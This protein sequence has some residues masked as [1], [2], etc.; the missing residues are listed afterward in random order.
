[1]ADLRMLANESEVR[2]VITFGTKKKKYH[3]ASLKPEDFADKPEIRNKYFWNKIRSLDRFH[4]PELSKSEYEAIAKDFRRT[5]KFDERCLK[6]ETASSYY[7]RKARVEA[8][9]KD[10]GCKASDIDLTDYIWDERYYVRYSFIENM[11]YADEMYRDDP[12]RDDDREASAYTVYIKQDPKTSAIDVELWDELYY[13]CTKAIQARKAMLLSKVD[14][15]LG[16]LISVL[17]YT[18]GFA[19]NATSH[20]VATMQGFKKFFAELLGDKEFYEFLTRNNDI[21]VFAKD[22]L[23]HNDYV[24][25]YRSLCKLLIRG[26]DEDMAY[27]EDMLKAVDDPYLEELLEFREHVEVRSIYDDADSED[28]DDEDVLD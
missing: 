25:T 6:Y 26:T 18:N 9:A 28:A 8:V 1:M 23:T 4:I 21:T 22:E 19:D 16:F 11:H 24:D 7:I 13:F 12:D 2:E 17:E 5:S 20:Q 3:I 10:L 27:F 15:C 14:K